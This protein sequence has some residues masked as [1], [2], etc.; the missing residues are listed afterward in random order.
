MDKPSDEG[1]RRYHQ[2]S[3]S[4]MH[5]LRL[6]VADVPDNTLQHFLHNYYI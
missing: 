2:G 4:L 3:C 6:T 5:Q 1:A